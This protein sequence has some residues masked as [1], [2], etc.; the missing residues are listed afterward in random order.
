MTRVE[1]LNMIYYNQEP[2]HRT[3]ETLAGITNYHQ[4]MLDSNNIILCEKGDRVLGYV[5][6]W[7][8]DWKQLKRILKGRKFVAPFEDL[9]SGRIC[10]IANLW[11]DKDARRGEV[12]KG[13][14]K[15]FDQYTLKCKY[16]CGHETREDNKF[17]IYKRS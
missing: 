9:N 7:L 13:L 15:R 14:K 12:F 10:Y 3:I 4:A 11:I 5:E 8:L 17:K 1:Q 16:F 2:W 6:F